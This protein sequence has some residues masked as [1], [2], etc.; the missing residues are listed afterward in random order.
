MEQLNLQLTLNNNGSITAS[1][2]KISNATRYEA[3][4][5]Q[6]GKDNLIYNEK[7]LQ[8]A[9]Y[10]SI[11]DLEPNFQYRVVVTAYGNAAG[12]ISDAKQLLIPL[13]FYDDK[14]MAIPQNINAAATDNSV[15]I[16]W[17]AVVRASS[18]DILFNGTTYNVKETTKTFTGLLPKTNYSYSV[19]AKNTKVTGLYSTA[20]MIMTLPQT[21]AVPK[22]TGRNVTEDSITI[23]WEKISGADSYDILFN[24]TAYHET[25]TSRAFTGL[26]PGKP[27]TF[28]IRAKNTD[29]TGAYTAIMTITTAPQPPAVISATSSENSVTVNW[30]AV[31]GARNYVLRFEGVEYTVAGTS[32]IIS[33]L[34][35][36]TTYTYQVRSKGVDGTGSYSAVKTIRTLPQIPA[37]PTGI[38]GISTD[39]SVTI[40]WAAVVSATGYD[41]LFNGSIYNTAGINRTFT[42][43]QP[44]TDYTCSVRAKNT[45]G[46]GAY[47]NIITIKTAPSAPANIRVEA[48]DETI[49]FNWDNIPGATGYSIIFNGKNYSVKNPSKTFT[50]LLSNTGYTYQLCSRN[51]DGS[52]AYSA[53]KTVKTTPKPPE[54]TTVSPTKESITISWNTVEGA[55]G[56]DILFDGKVYPVTGNSITITGLTPGKTYNYQI[57]CKNADGS[58]SYGDIKTAA[59]IPNPPGVPINVNATATTN[60]VTVTWSEVN[61]ATGYD[62]SL[63]NTVYSV[64]ET[65]K[66]ITGLVSGIKHSYKV[67]A[68]NAGGTSAYSTV[69]FI[70]TVPVLPTVP[71][72]LNATATYNSVTI[73]W[74]AVVGAASYDLLFNGATYNLGRNTY[75]FTGLKPQTS[76]TYAVRAKNE[77]GDS[78]YT[79]TRTV[80]TLQAPPAVPENLKATSTSDTVIITWGEV[81]GATDYDVLFDEIVYSVTAATKI[82]T[83]LVPG[84]SHTY[85]VRAKNA[86]GM[87]PYSVKK[88][89]RTIP[90]EPDVPDF[91]TTS[92][93]AHSVSISWYSAERATDYD[94]LFNGAVT[95]VSDTKIKFTELEANTA[96]TYQVRANNLLGSSVYSTERTVR[97]RLE[98][99]EIIKMESEWDSVTISW[100]AVPGAYDYDIDFNGTVYNVKGTV[101]E[102]NGL[103]S[104]TGYDFSVRAK[105]NDV[106]SEYS[107]IFRVFTKMAIPEVPTNVRAESTFST[108][109]VNWD[110]VSGAS[111]Y[112]V[113]FD[114]KE[115]QEIYIAARN[116]KKAKTGKIF[117]DLEPNTIHTFCVRA[118]NESGSSDYS[119]LQMIKTQ[120][121]NENGLPNIKSNKKYPDGKLP[122]MGLDPVNALTG[123]FLWSYSWLQD[124]GKD[125]LHFTAMYDSQRDAKNKIMG[126]KWTYSLNYLLYMDNEYAYFSTP[127]GQIIP[128]VKNLENDSFDS[129]YDKSSG[130]VMEKKEDYYL[131][132]DIDNTEY[133][134]SSE[135]CLHQIVDGGV[136]TYCFY[137]NEDGEII[138]IEGRHGAALEFTY[139]KGH[140]SS[141]SD[142]LGNKIILA[143]TDDCLTSATNAHGERMLFS[144]DISGNMSEITDFSGQSYLINQYDEKKR[145][146]MQNIPGKGVSFVTYDETERTTTFTDELGNNTKYYYD[147]K[148]RVTMVE[149]GESC[150][151][152]KYN[153]KGQMSQQIDG[154]G[155]ITQ[156]EYDENGRIIHVVYPDET[157]EHIFYN[158]TNQ[159]SRLINRDGTTCKYTYD[160][161]NN[162]ILLQDERGNISRFS[163]DKMDNL[164]TH[165]DK[166]GYIWNY[167]YD[168]KNHLQQA[169][170]PEGN[171]Y[172]Y[173]HDAIGRLLSYTSPTGKTTTYQYSE[174]GDLL[175]IIEEDGTIVFN[176]D[177]NG[178]QTDITDKRSNTRRIEY[179]QMG[180]VSLATDFLGN[181]YQ[182]FYD[183]KGNLIRETDPLGYSKSYVYDSMGYNTQWTDQNGGTTNYSFNVVGQLT[184][185]RDANGGCI[186]YAYNTMGQ[187]EGV[188][189]PLNNHT[190]FTYDPMGR[191]I[192]ITN[193][194]GHSINYSYD[195]AGNLLT[196]T[197]ENGTVWQYVYEKENKL[198]SIIS[199]LG[200]VHFT[201]DKLGRVVAV[202]DMEGNQETVQYD[203]DGNIIK[204]SDKENNY[205]TYD[206]DISGRIS[207]KT[208]AKGGRTKYTYDKNG[209]CTKII[210][211][212][213]NVY[214]YEYDANNQIIK[215]V[216]PLGY[217]TLYEY[218][219]RGYLSSIINPKGGKTEFVYDGNG[220]LVKETNPLGGSK[221][222][223][224]DSLNRLIQET[225]EEGY[226][227][228]FM[229]DANGNRISYTDAN[230]NEWTYEYDAINRVT[231]MTNHNGGQMMFAYTNTGKIAKITDQEGA[232]T[233][234]FYDSMGRLLKMTDALEHSLNWNYD[235]LGRVT[236]QTDANGNITEYEYSPSGNLIRIKAPE[237][238]ITAYTYDAMGQML[239][240]TDEI[241]NVTSYEYDILG[242]V[243]AITDAMGGK[244]SFTYTA[245][246][247]IATVTNAKGSITSYR[248]DAC[249]NLT[250]IIDALGNTTVFEYD[251]MNNRIKE[252]LSDSEQQK[253]GT[254]YKYD[255]RG[256]VI[257][258]I[259]P[260]SDAKV[261]TYDGNGNMLS[262]LDEDGNKTAVYYDFNNKPTGM[263]YSN[264]WNAAFRYNKRGELVELKDWNGTVTME[265]GRTGKLAKVT[266]HNGRIIGYNYDANG[267][268]TG[269]TYPDSST[270]DYAYDKNNRLTKVTDAEGETTQYTYNPVGNVL[271]IRKPGNITSYTYNA[272]GL[273]TQIQYQLKDGTF[274]ENTFSYDALGSVQSS[275]RKGSNTQLASNVSYA[276]D[277]LGQLL[278]YREGQIT[279]S[280]DY[281]VFGNR[282]SK[283]KNGIQKA[284]YQ[285]NTLN[286]LVARTEN[287]IDYN[288][289]YDRRGNLI[290]EKRNGI[291]ISQYSYDATGHMHIGKNLETGEKT[292]YGF[293]ALYMRVKNVQ[294]LE[295]QTSGYADINSLEPYRTRETSYVIDY[296]SST[297]NEIMSYE[298]DFGMTR[299]TF[300]KDYERLG[301][302]VIPLP[303]G[304]VTSRRD[305][306]QKVIGKSYFQSDIYGS[307][308]FV[309]N[310]QGEVLRYAQRDAW[311]S[312]KIPVF[313]DLNSAGVENSL[314][315]TN[316]NYDPVIS[317]YF[318]Q[319]RFYD[320]V[321]GRMLGK[322]PVKR[323][324]NGYPYC[325]NDPV[326]YVDPTGEIANILLGGAL[327]GLTGGVFGFAGSALS[328]VLS[329][330]KFSIKKA[331]GAAANGAV[332]GT[333]RGALVGSGVGLAASL[334]SNF[335]A[336][337]AGTALEQQIGTGKVNVRESIAGGLSNAVSGAIYGNAPLKS[338]GEAYWRGTAAGA[339]TAAI[340]NLTNAFGNNSEIGVRYSKIPTVTENVLPYEV[341][342]DPRA[343]CGAPNP[344]SGNLSYPSVRGYQYPTS[345]IKD[346]KEKKSGFSFAGFIKD[347]IAGGVTGGLSSVAFYGGGKAVEK[348]RDCV[349]G[350]S[351]TVGRPVQGQG[352]SDRGYNPKPG[353]R[354]LNG[355]VKNNVSPDAELKLFTDSSGFNNNNGNVG[356]MF[357]RFGV[358]SHG[359]ISP[360][361]HQPYRN[362]N[363]R[364]GYVYGGTYEGRT[365]PGLIDYPT[366]GDINHLYQYLVNGKY[367]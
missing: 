37:V 178:N 146:V 205:T 118:I 280:Y 83:G 182:F 89:I 221:L 277:A 206:Y 352:Y 261:Y 255:K 196:K 226:N 249:G 105:N 168:D 321:Q 233:N 163:Y 305:I 85:Q 54:D 212:G 162:L 113:Q 240:K 333:V 80:T 213:D 231:S 339:A 329:G 356:G 288:Y 358:D 1:W 103:K 159:P 43:L 204:F 346:K 170:D 158:E 77:A 238:N 34:K 253:C 39:N 72:N 223:Y 278:S 276:Y 274:L 135:L 32:Q 243:T 302:K 184:E 219:A 313:E 275:E 332:V 4:M 123:A 143:Y 232:E 362:V 128:F 104:E 343:G 84:T 308:M 151:Q 337:T 314:C 294:T 132:R 69:Q 186:K 300:G 191:I 120:I 245:N 149:Q 18:Y 74:D 44:N 58:S 230:G 193:A 259:N 364:T 126:N 360:H 122:Y 148:L 273:P 67:R 315:F 214:I 271:S 41:V 176:Y 65:N 56:Y 279:E 17:N 183:E 63:D 287:G 338:A 242:Q 76:Y 268:V 108:V 285:Y 367:R 150:I 28:Q 145:V 297:N 175:R 353:E 284:A 3:Y 180:Q 185:V 220:N 263:N 129:V 239:T 48:N 312:L 102:F 36:N 194:L 327:G 320:P 110:A 29:T 289:D 236:S 38:T 11:A 171:I 266:D 345:L 164:I 138:R 258:E 292:E 142:V 319:A 173:F 99:P 107:Q 160:T 295:Q 6:I 49:E 5:Y 316:Y 344:F 341:K 86:S 152:N 262:I 100:N 61:G 45:D 323:G 165:T 157:D 351:A 81:S 111:D 179:N 304:L 272:K 354:T 134:F 298:K 14:P 70:K 117:F 98:T 147:E 335:I 23:I 349:K 207:V 281:D 347:V 235:S 154:L 137:R 91:F 97:T 189:D 155:N 136:I 19:R 75:L 265:Y 13:N 109:T 22:I 269:I 252:Y 192:C 199:D 324:L 12:T 33:G 282:I 153:E 328:Q 181:M 35:S 330:E 79:S 200:S 7:N 209:N 8:A 291:P 256:H 257:Q 201:Y 241:G 156:M 248:Y 355:Y 311:G 187:I 130:Y 94:V 215:V 93:T 46:T 66:T 325:N 114:G 71:A 25:G 334:A 197:D 112:I 218:D 64:S 246:K 140:I 2:S 310:G 224:Y 119:D 260:V 115:E 190:N 15:T 307:V 217:V 141:V 350:G 228:F 222:Y 51:K 95:K 53:I 296:L 42:D 133:L 169:T 195:E 303:D 161:R 92:A 144:Y 254:I 227:R 60:S 31:T 87:S 299:I 16:N 250:Q 57:R 203:G 365:G 101:I 286:Q 326:D 68:K 225:D 116:R 366:T 210:D 59:T 264:G 167:A 208:D 317:K 62:I 26:E 306:A 301:Q 247:E 88:T 216:N 309:S 283:K 293:N 244:T 139:E 30:Q 340:N 177:V 211:P 90:I 172:A 198:A 24:G 47:S 125:A 106:T 359:G 131:V 202:Q 9:A 229:Y 234:Y 27:Y 342:R 127:Y 124:Y 166:N 318:A 322:D 174:T 50:G 290:E 267:N 251:A 20:K 73:S 21:L 121:N 78:A 96:Y 331:F 270:V 336:G 361:V 82:I 348:I 52:S 363:P 10:T 40:S 188:I 55:T 357:K 237:G